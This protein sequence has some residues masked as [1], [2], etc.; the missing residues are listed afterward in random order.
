[1]PTYEA[2]MFAQPGEVGSLF[3]YGA[4]QGKFELD[5]SYSLIDLETSGFNPPQAKILEIAILK[6]NVNGDVIDEFSTLIDPMAMDVGRTD[7][8]GITSKMLKHAPTFAEA[9]GSI[10]K[11]IQNSI[12]VA[13]NARFEENFLANEFRMAGVSLPSLPAL[14]TLWLSRQILDLENYKLE[15]VIANYNERIDDAHTALGD[16]RAMAKVLP[17]MFEESKK[18]YYPKAFSEL[19]QINTVFKAK[20][21]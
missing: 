5:G 17:R 6:V 15:T 19:P 9:V 1:M 4:Y 16:V 10:L 21:R 8:H 2:P 3:A 7:I 18:L 12:L 13:H 20:P 14:D 11:I